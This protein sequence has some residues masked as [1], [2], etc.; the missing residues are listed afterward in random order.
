MQLL[1]SIAVAHGGVAQP[2]CMC[3]QWAP[4]PA[5]PITLGIGRA[6][7]KA[8]PP[9]QIPTGDGM[10]GDVLPLGMV[11]PMSQGFGDV[12]GNMRQPAWPQAGC[13]WGVTCPSLL[14]WVLV[15]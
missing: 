2:S 1:P 14:V 10:C 7:V 11:L 9:A 15:A 8:P 3:L 5:G 13:S 6:V 12:M 4:A